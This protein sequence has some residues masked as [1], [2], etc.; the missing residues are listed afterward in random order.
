MRSGHGFLDLPVSIYAL[1]L[2]H[3]PGVR[4]YSLIL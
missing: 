1:V 3:R 4:R 2:L